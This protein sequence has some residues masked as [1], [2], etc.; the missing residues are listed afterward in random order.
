M[1]KSDLGAFDAS[2]YLFPHFSFAF[3]NERDSRP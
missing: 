3:C 2:M 1:L